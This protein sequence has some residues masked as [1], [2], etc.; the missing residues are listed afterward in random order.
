MNCQTENVIYCISCNRCNEVY[1]GQ[2]SKSLS[3]RFSQHLGYIRN[4][5]NHTAAGKR[6]EPTGQHFNGPGHQG[7]RD[8][9]IRVVY[10]FGICQIVQIGKNLGFS[11]S[12]T[13]IILAM[14]AKNR[15]IPAL[16]LAL[17]N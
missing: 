11:G 13:I 7:I 3:Q 16:N 10:N 5:H 4:F 14:F 8:V 15:K 12:K 2:T 1:V 17:R 6:I 9:Q